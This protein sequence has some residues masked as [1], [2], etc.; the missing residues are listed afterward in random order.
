MKT[1]EVFDSYR[2]LAGG[3]WSEEV[4]RSQSV[5]ILGCGALGSY[6][7]ECLAAM[8]VRTIALI[9]DD[10]VQPHNRLR[11][12]L[13]TADDI[14]RAKVEAVADGLRR[15]FGDITQA[16]PLLGNVQTML[17]H[18]L[19]R[20][21]ACV[22]L[23]TDNRAA[24]QYGCRRA[25]TAGT[26]HLSGAI[27]EF[28]GMVSGVFAPPQSACYECTLNERERRELMAA[29]FSCAPKPDERAPSVPTT[30]I[31][32]SISAAWMTHLFLRYA[33]GERDGIVGQ[34]IFINPLRN[35]V[36][37]AEF[38]RRLDCACAGEPHVAEPIALNVSRDEM[39]PRLLL[40]EAA[41][42]CGKGGWVVLDYP[43]VTEEMCRCGLTR[44]LD[45]PR[46][47]AALSVCPDCASPMT[48]I[49]LVNMLS[50][51]S[52]FAD[53]TF[54]QLGLPLLHSVTVRGSQGMEV[55]ELSGDAERVWVLG[56]GL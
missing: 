46:H 2:A 27:D 51:Q 36:Q 19:V 34:R 21:A 5:I 37:V 20:R 6:L 40:R 33:H 52:P 18:G 29:R 42:V 50:E 8:G 43:L 35:T 3:Q 16:I 28:F 23:C 31:A 13:V 45:P 24:R 48:A 17:G 14:G 1:R 47:E 22:F 32:A 25:R 11:M 26:P 10:I 9:D 54:A 38:Q 30:P 44:T 15:R 53:C 49:A 55:F 7:A 56:S 39:T 12:A 4:V 41:S